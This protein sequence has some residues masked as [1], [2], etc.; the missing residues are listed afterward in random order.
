MCKGGEREREREREREECSC[1]IS[2]L[3]PGEG[4]SFVATFA[5][6][7]A[8]AAV[9][10]EG[11]LQGAHKQPA[12]L[13]GEHRGSSPLSGMD[14]CRLSSTRGHT[15]PRRQPHQVR[16]ERNSTNEWLPFSSAA[17]FTRRCCSS[18]RISTPTHHHLKTSGTRH[19]R[20]AKPSHSQL[21][22]M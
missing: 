17:G 18:P 4:N 21:N 5:A 8:G 3:V 15:H 19:A 9:S 13:L 14:A 1:I 11:K 2:H 16:R 22:T 20:C 6:R 7:K 12:S 10:S